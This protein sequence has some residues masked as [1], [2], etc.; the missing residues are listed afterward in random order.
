M[1]VK[2]KQ[3]RAAKKKARQRGRP[4]GAARAGWDPF[5]CVVTPEFARWHLLECLAAVDDDAAAAGPLAEGLLRPDG[6]LPPEL[7]RQALADLLAELVGA[8][9]AQG[10]RPT[11]LAQLV[12]RRLSGRHLPPLLGLLA[13]EAARHPARRVADAWR[14]DLAAAGPQLPLDLAG[15]AGVR[16]ALELAALL[17]TLP[18]IAVLLPPPGTAAG[19]ARTGE[20]GDPR[21]LARVR[22]LLAKAEATEFPE[23]AEALSAKAQELVS[24]HALGQLLEQVDGVREAPPT[25][26]RRLWLEPPYVFAKALLVQAVAEANRCRSVV[27]EALGCCTLLGRDDDLAAV[28]ALV[29]SLLVQASSAMLRHGR[30]ADRTGTSRTRS[31]RQSF[32]VSYAERI[33][34]RLQEA[35][36]DAARGTGR[37]AELVPVLR[38]HAEQLDAHCSAL[39]PVLVSRGATVGNAKGWAA[40]RAAADLA[41]LDTDLQL[42]RAAG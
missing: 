3:R 42:T 39:F 41:L 26:A 7:A 14:D 35:S 34:E 8:V 28:D 31:F 27:S 36:A 10:W 33:G 15:P 18:A 30:Q 5:V 19:P 11:D 12:P 29:T 24:R 20:A 40:G 21:L 13:A 25:T 6:P 17:A 32:L 23:E 38:R 22:A 16:A 37:S 2:N 4:G 9:V 1:G